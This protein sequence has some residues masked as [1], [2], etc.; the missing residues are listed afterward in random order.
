MWHNECGRRPGGS[1]SARLPASASCP[2]LQ[3]GQ[4]PARRGLRVTMR[5]P[6]PR[7]DAA[8]LAQRQMTLVGGGQRSVRL[9]ASCSALSP[10]LP[11]RRRSALRGRRVIVT[12]ALPPPYCGVRSAHASGR[13]GT[14]RSFA[15]S[16][17]LVP[18]AP[19]WAALRAARAVSHM[20]T[21]PHPRR[22]GG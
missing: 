20:V 11:C 14:A 19:L 5:Q 2:Q 10:S 3:C 7:P 15:A 13:K 6:R 22:C 16:V 17:S 8:G 21:A 1:S 18:T 12:A 9:P 4:R